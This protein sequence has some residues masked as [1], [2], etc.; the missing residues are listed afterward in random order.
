[1]GEINVYKTGQACKNL[2]YTFYI[3]VCLIVLSKCRRISDYIDNLV[4]YIN[5][6]NITCETDSH[7]LKVLFGKFTNRNKYLNNRY[8]CIYVHYMYR[9]SMVFT[10]TT[11]YWFTLQIPGQNLSI[12]KTITIKFWK[13]RFNVVQAEQ[14]CCHIFLKTPFYVIFN[15]TFLMI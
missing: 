11:R 5:I 10:C 9:Y 14:T 12:N 13:D 2:K 6:I 8:I 4:I 3:P 7:N 15:V 1:M